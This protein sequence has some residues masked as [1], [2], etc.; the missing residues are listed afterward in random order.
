MLNLCKVRVHLLHRSSIPLRHCL[1]NMRIDG[2]QWQ[3][4]A[5]LH[6]L[7][8]RQKMLQLKYIWRGKR[9]ANWFLSLCGPA[10]YRRRSDRH[11]MDN[12]AQLQLKLGGDW[13]VCD[14]L[15]M[16]N[17][18]SKRWISIKNDTLF[19]KDTRMTPNFGNN[20]LDAVV[21]AWTAANARTHDKY[22]INYRLARHLKLAIVWLRF[23]C[24]AFWS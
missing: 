11:W 2:V 10:M 5:A 3:V 20:I 4:S 7:D 13:C 8:C 9:N 6:L 18:H 14:A 19:W 17:T 15:C 24:R 16:K 22:D 12:M 23:F 21:S 1:L